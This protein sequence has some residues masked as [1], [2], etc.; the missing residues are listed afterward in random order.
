M[1]Q[2][3]SVEKFSR[4]DFTEWDEDDLARLADFLRMFT[5]YRLKAEVG[6]SNSDY[7]LLKK[8]SSDESSSTVVQGTSL[9][10][11]PGIARPTL[12]DQDE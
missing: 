12:R 1:T 5:D 2:Y 8:T 10:T 7:H 11:A 4:D 6:D 3:N 9:D